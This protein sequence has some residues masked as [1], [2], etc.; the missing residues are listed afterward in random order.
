MRNVDGIETW[1]DYCEDQNGRLTGMKLTGREE[2]D[3]EAG[4]LY[5][6]YIDV[7]SSCEP[8]M[9]DMGYA[10][11]RPIVERHPSAGGRRSV[12]HLRLV[13]SPDEA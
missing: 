4:V 12:N 1:C 6:R 13:R 8:K 3:R 10:N 5:P 2:F 11:I 7:C 9:V